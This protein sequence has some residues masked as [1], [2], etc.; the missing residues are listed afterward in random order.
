MRRSLKNELIRITGFFFSGGVSF[1]IDIALFTALNYFLHPFIHN[2][3]IVVST[4]IARV[5]S[6]LCNYYIN[7]RW[8]F[9]NYDMN[10]IIKYYALVLIQMLVSAWT[11]FEMS[12][13][14][15]HIHVT[16]IK[17]AVDIVLFFVNYCIQKRFVFNVGSNVKRRING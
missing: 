3:A 4:I 17:I 1:A 12:R 10:S 5:L 6:S 9:K 16:I 2:E 8:V 11:V 7:S 13:V 14:F 15:A